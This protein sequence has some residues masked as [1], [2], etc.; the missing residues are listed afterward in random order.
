MQD[1]S[2]PDKD[3]RELFRAIHSVF[4]GK[5]KEVVKCLRGITPTDRMGIEKMINIVLCVYQSIHVLARNPD[6]LCWFLKTEG[7]NQQVS[8]EEEFKSFVKGEAESFPL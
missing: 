4:V 1:K 5:C 3:H 2:L 6:K 8:N 7:S